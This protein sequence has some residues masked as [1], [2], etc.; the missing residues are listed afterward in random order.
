[1]SMAEELQ[2]K[3]TKNPFLPLSSAVY[4]LLFS[5]IINFDYKPE[6]RL[7]VSDIV[8]EAG[9]SRTPVQEAIEMLK[10]DGLVYMKKSKGVY[11]SP[12][13][14]EDYGNFFA[15]RSALEIAAIR[16]TAEVITRSQMRELNMYRK[17]LQEA[18]E[19]KSYHKII[20][21]EDRFHS[22]LVECCG[23]PHIIE[24]Y[25]S[26]GS[27]IQRYRFYVAVDEAAF[28]SKTEQHN[29]I[30]SS[31]LHGDPDC[32]AAAMKSHLVYY[33]VDYEKNYLAALRNFDQ[34]QA[35]KQQ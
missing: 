12:F 35:F 14:P 5:R 25:R 13:S 16:K 4:E 29:Y 6:S 3:L 9:V 11:V 18:Y 32:C 1:M 7:V 30:Y 28:A 34:I 17:A 27:H 21:G 24:A 20:S 33:P 2:A 31:L 10:E 26:L 22:F 8:E 23:N 19:Q 15:L